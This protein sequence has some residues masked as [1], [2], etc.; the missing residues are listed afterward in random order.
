LEAIIDQVV[1][2]WYDTWSLA[3]LCSTS[4][5]AFGYVTGFQYDEW[6]MNNRMGK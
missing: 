4:G 2:G 5:I 6:G 3:K 1:R